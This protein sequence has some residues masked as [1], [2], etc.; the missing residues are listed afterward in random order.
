MRL[1]ESDG[2]RRKIFTDNPAELYRFNTRPHADRF[3]PALQA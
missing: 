1:V 3:I 2:V